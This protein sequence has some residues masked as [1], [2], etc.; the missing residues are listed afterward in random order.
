MKSLMQLSL[1]ILL[2][3]PQ[4]VAAEREPTIAVDYLPERLGDTL[5]RTHVLVRARISKITAPE[6]GDVPSRPQDD[7]W[8]PVCC[9]AEMDV[10]ESY[11]KLAESHLTF[12]V[13]RMS[14][15]GEVRSEPMEAIVVLRRAPQGLI[16]AGG[17][18]TSGVYAITPNGCTSL[19]DV[20]ADVPVE[21]A[22]EL[23]CD[24]L[25]YFDEKSAPENSRKWTDR[26]ASGNQVQVQAAKTYID[27][28]RDDVPFP[29]VPENAKQALDHLVSGRIAEASAALDYFNTVTEAELPPA[30]VMDRIEKE[31][32]S[33]QPPKQYG[34][35]TPT[36]KNFHEF[37]LRA[38]QTLVRV[39]DPP[40]VSR[41]YDLFVKDC[42]L[43]RRLFPEKIGA[44]ALSEPVLRLVLKYPGPERRQRAEYLLTTA[45]EVREVG[46]GTTRPYFSGA[47]PVW[48]LL[49]ET[50]GDDMQQLL[51]DIKKDPRK[52]HFFY[53]EYL[54][55]DLQGDTGADDL[56]ALIKD[57]EDGN[58]EALYRIQ[59]LL[60]APCQEL[61]PLM[62]KADWYGRGKRTG[63]HSPEL[64]MLP[65]IAAQVMPNPAF[66]P[67]IKAAIE[68][69]QTPELVWALY[70]CGEEKEALRLAV[71][72]VEHPAAVSGDDAYIRFKDPPKYTLLLGKTRA[73]EAAKVLDRQVRPKALNKWAK[74]YGQYVL[75]TPG[76]RIPPRNPAKETLLQAATLALAYQG[77]ESVVRLKELLVGE[78][79]A[80]RLAAAIGL[81]YNGNESGKAELDN[82]VQSET[83]PFLDLWYAVS[84]NTTGPVVPEVEYLRN[85]A[86][87]KVYLERL[88]RGPFNPFQEAFFI[89]D[90]GLLR[91]YPN[92][93]IPLLISRLEKPRMRSDAADLLFYATRH[94]IPENTTDIVG[95]WRKYLDSLQVE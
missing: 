5:M 72:V 71:D 33:L 95:A 45:E 91:D 28:V 61:V 81:L 47:D 63:L 82:F 57:Y 40:T 65:R 11:P 42:R 17:F 75:Q 30:V 50:P 70:T 48:P 89:R 37:S 56:S 35:V 27:I 43:V 68:K 49:K 39:A 62:L 16:A 69:C 4:A 21:L 59:P 23:L 9:V 36:M 55:N 25:D 2:A 54:K 60:T 15:G 6:R 67:N 58:S 53:P 34:V 13:T 44:P 80:G 22:W 78:D 19:P 73:P 79:P 84:S 41:A 86:V 92:V 14:K 8:Y 88:A 52:Y 29:A 20:G 85:G 38:I 12:T 87:D 18:P 66:V 24:V 64:Q 51:L 7:S 93:I 31:Y 46:Y 3:V 83:P 76:N 74:T 77:P 94:R 10:T 32:Q 1:V 90:S 26:L